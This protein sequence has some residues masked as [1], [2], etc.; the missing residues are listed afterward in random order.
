MSQ[1]QISPIEQDV[2]RD[3]AQE[4][5]RIQ[6]RHTAC[7][8]RCNLGDVA[9]LSVGGARILARAGMRSPIDV[10]FY[11][12]NKSVNIRAKIAWTRATGEGFKTEVGLAFTKL[13]RIQREAIQSLAR[14]T[15][16]RSLI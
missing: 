10:E 2:L 4:C 13:T 7:S 8:V 14:G 11:A 12:M 16:H 5:A 9:D 6:P 3:A 1:S 15:T